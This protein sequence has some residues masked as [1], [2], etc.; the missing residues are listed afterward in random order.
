MEIRKRVRPWWRMDVNGALV[1]ILRSGPRTLELEKGKAGIVIGSQERLAAVLET[2]IA[3][4]RAGEL[5]AALEAAAGVF[6]RAIPKRKA[7]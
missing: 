7:A 1:L 5:D 6:G 4:A 3:A 2:L